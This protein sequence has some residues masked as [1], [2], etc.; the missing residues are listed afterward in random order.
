MVTK[1]MCKYVQFY[2][3]L[4]DLQILHADK[5][6]WIRSEGLEIPQVS[7][8][9][10]ATDPLN[11]SHTTPDIN[12]IFCDLRDETHVTTKQSSQTV[13][14]LMAQNEGASTLSAKAQMELLRLYPYVPLG[15]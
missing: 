4:Q 15:I 8:L 11:P 13:L 5:V 2:A 9:T 3:S 12:N 6:Y 14:L 7:L 10:A 1:T